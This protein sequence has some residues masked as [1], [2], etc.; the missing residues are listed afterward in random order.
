MYVLQCKK[1]RYSFLATFHNNKS[2]NEERQKYTTQNTMTGK[3]N[4]QTDCQAE[5]EQDHKNK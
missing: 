2:E 3:C 4:E 1:I 5:I